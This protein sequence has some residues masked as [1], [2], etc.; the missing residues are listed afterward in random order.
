MTISSEGGRHPVEK[1]QPHA[2]DRASSF[3]NLESPGHAPSPSQTGAINRCEARVR[4]INRIV[5]RRSKRPERPNQSSSW[6]ANERVWR[7]QETH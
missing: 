1:A 7:R 5:P 4:A 2:C 3:L 6:R